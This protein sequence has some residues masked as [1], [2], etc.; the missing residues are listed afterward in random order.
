MKLSEFCI[1]RPVFTTVLSLILIVIGVIGFLRVTVRQFPNIDFPIIT[2]DTNYSGASPSLIESTITTPIEDVLSNIDGLKQIGS[3]SSQ[4]NSNIRLKFNLGTDL[5]VAAGQIRDKLATVINSLPKDADQPVIYRMDTSDWETVILSFTDNNRSMMSLT[6]YVTRYI[7]PKL[8]KVDGVSRIEIFGGETYAMRMQLNPEKMAARN[9][10]VNDVDAAIRA[11]NADVAGGQ[12]KTPSKYYSVIATSKL[13]SA[14]EFNNIIVREDKGYLIRFKDIGN[15]KVAPEDRR[16][17]VRSDGKQVL[18]VGV[19]SKS[20]ANPIGIADQVINLM[21]QIQSSL[22]Q[23][24]HGKVV[25]NNAYY[26]HASLKNVYRTIFIAIVL[27]LIVIFLFLGSIRATAIP[28]ITI[29]ICLIAVFGFIYVANYT[30]NEITLLALVLAIGLVVDDAIVMLENIHRHIENGEQ[31]LIAAMKGSREIGFAIIAMTITLAAVYAPVAF[32]PGMVGIIFRRFAFTLAITVL[33]SGF[34]ALTLSP[35]MCSRIISSVENKYSKW[36]DKAFGAFVQSYR[37][38]LT[39]ILRYRL[40]I[41]VALVLIITGGVFLYK[42]LSA[43]TAPAEDNGTLLTIITAPSNSSLGYMNDYA[44]KIEKLFAAIPEEIRYLTVIDSPTGARA[45]TTLK[46]WSE[47]K[48]SQQ[49]ISAELNKKLANITGVQATSIK[50]S[51]FGGDGK[52]GDAVEFVITTTQSYNRLNTI[53]E[54]IEKVV[55]EWPGFSY[56]ESSLKMDNS[57]FE[58]AVHRDLAA[59]LQVNM[60]DIINT[61]STM[62][63]G[64]KVTKFDI[65]GWEYNVILQ[66][67]LKQREDVSTIHNLYV[68][69]QPDKM[70][71][72]SS[73]VTIKNTVGP[74]TLPHY[75]RL[76][77]TRITAQL[78]PSYKMSDAIQFVRN[79][80]AKN[81]PDDAE[82]S[83]TGAT[84]RYIESGHQMAIVF[85]L[86]IIFIFLVLAAQFESFIDP[87]IILFTV[88]LSIIGALSILKITGGSLNIFSEIGFVTLIGLITKHG[89]LITEF[90]NQQRAKGEDLYNAVI[91]AACLRIRPILMT[92]AAMVL[93]ALPLALATGAG[94]NSRHQ[95][96]WV[97][98]GG[99][100][101]G[102]F[103]SLFVIPVA[104]SY[105]GRF[106][107]IGKAPAG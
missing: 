28:I 96:G 102:T 53:A 33:I 64:S 26:V 51:G 38:N 85:A 2:V 29:P 77:S 45:F 11:Q 31:P 18:G 52:Y 106:K 92:T 72:L 54:N 39:F 21:P 65:G 81:L 103:F 24:M 36:L 47:R 5:D 42:S 61:L 84:E 73:L 30:I 100:L 57:Q 75:D 91:E 19:L 41:I 63:G 56:I 107:K 58:I 90:A 46:P 16:M 80:M 89:I 35:M 105:F 49:E 9:V 101:F 8:E 44:K 25:F 94:A 74:S 13:K 83:F 23:G 1:K 43:E 27:V 78:N 3:E 50:L 4:D 15:A 40:L 99:L 22:P 32:T 82:Y 34:I 60:N 76:R 95:I 97:I 14:A 7:K 10:T 79:I 20:T 48:R 104:Y 12:I 67:P 59:Q 66:L 55:R 98:V 87:F 6:D 93:G 71:P 37:K 70:I 86:A 17:I 68:R 88:P 69:S 62:I